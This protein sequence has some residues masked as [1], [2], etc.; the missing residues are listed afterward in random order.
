MKYLSILLLCSSAYL[1]S[2]ETSFKIDRAIAIQLA[3][4][5]LF[6]EEFKEFKKPL[7]SMVREVNSAIGD[8]S[9]QL[10]DQEIEN[11]MKEGIKNQY[12]EFKNTGMTKDELLKRAAKDKVNGEAY[13][14]LAQKNDHKDSIFY[15]TQRLFNIISE[16]SREI[17]SEYPRRQPNIGELASIARQ[18]VIISNRSSA[19]LVP[20]ADVPVSEPDA[21]RFIPYNTFLDYSFSSGSTSSSSS[22]EGEEDVH[23]GII[24]HANI[25][26]NG[27]LAPDGW[28]GY[29]KERHKLQF[30]KNC[31]VA[32]TGLFGWNA[33]N[34]VLEL[35]KR[36]DDLSTG[37]AINVVITPE[38][39]LKDTSL[40][41]E[42][43][44][45]AKE[46]L[47]QH[48]QDTYNE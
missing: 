23:T 29:A 10:T 5:E 45:N 32:N 18:S 41:R 40:V 14:N 24:D 33:A 28:A 44:Q 8:G 26:M 4:T 6:T 43:I 31:I 38:K 15:N 11:A 35:K 25:V 34:H 37:V 22:S 13:S 20:C 39:N 36:M 1:C 2:M 30:N 27:D 16:A 3:A 42:G 9:R 7:L 21:L 46:A 47:D 17:L 19:A 12:R 48:Y